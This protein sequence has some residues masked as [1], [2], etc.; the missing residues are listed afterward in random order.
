LGYK[1][2][3]GSR[4]AF[5]FPGNQAAARFPFDAGGFPALL[6]SLFVFQV[7]ASSFKQRFLHFL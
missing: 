1:K 6:L 5:P 4:L 2:A 3:G 7:I